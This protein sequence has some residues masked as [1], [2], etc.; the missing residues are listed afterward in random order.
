MSDWRFR[1]WI[2][3]R[4]NGPLESN[5]GDIVYAWIALA[6]AAR[7]PFFTEDGPMF[8][9]Y[10]Q[11]ETEEERLQREEKRR[12]EY[13]M[14][15]IEERKETSKEFLKT[16]G[17][18]IEKNP[19]ID[20]RDKKFVFTGLSARR[21]ALEDETDYAKLIE[22]RGGLTRSKVS[23]V[24]DY[25]IVDPA[26]AGDSKIR[27]AIENQKKGKPIRIIHMDD[28]RKALGLPADESS[29]ATNTS[30]T[31]KPAASATAKA[32]PAVKNSI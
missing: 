31:K 22:D 8:Y 29:V 26:G 18:N 4:C 24:T 10:S 2:K 32:S 13:R 14:R 25:L 6:Y 7:A 15:A 1:I 12:E 3:R 17:K 5:E 30:A 19:Q 11:E 20:F 28:F 21:Y 27:D 9:F 23:G 16:Y